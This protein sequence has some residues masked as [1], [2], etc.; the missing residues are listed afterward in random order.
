MCFGDW[1]ISTSILLNVKAIFICVTMN[2]Y[3]TPK[4]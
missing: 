1:I 2:E 4:S 3:L